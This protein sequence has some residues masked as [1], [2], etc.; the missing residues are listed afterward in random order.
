MP[1]RSFASGRNNAV[2]PGLS[3]FEAWAENYATVFGL[4]D[5]GDLAGLL[6][7]EPVLAATAVELRDATAWLVAN[8][9]AL[10]TS[11]GRY[12]GKLALHLAALQ[13]RLRDCRAVRY[14]RTVDAR[15]RDDR[16]TCTLC[17]GSGRVV[18]PHRA[19]V[20]GDNWVPLTVARGG[21]SYYTEA[22]L[23][24]CALGNWFGSR[25]EAEKRPGP[26]VEYEAI[27]PAWRVQMAARLVQQAAA[28]ALT[29]PLPS[30]RAVVGRLAD[31]YRIPRPQKSTDGRSGFAILYAAGLLACGPNGAGPPRP[32]PGG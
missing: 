14:Q 22:V 2:R 10:G 12:A 3:W 29:E 18:V 6:A 16:G 11:E 7:W 1:K 20:Q 23:C 28:A 19:G 4:R 15:E 26:F 25:M 5:A 27:N 32:G 8:P 17:G 21:P 24:S 30:L 31:Q 13:A 9:R